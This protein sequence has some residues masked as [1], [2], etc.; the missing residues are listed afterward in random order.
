MPT[1]LELVKE[2]LTIEEACEMAGVRVGRGRGHKRTALCPLHDDSSPS[3]AIFL[4]SNRWMCFSG[5]GQGDAIDLLAKLWGLSTGQAL[6]RLATEL[7]I[8]VNTYQDDERR[9]KRLEALQQERERRRKDR[10][11]ERACSKA[12]HYLKVL[13]DALD[14]P[15]QACETAWEVERLATH[16]HLLAKIDRILDDLISRDRKQREHGLVEAW[17]VFQLVKGARKKQSNA[18]NTKTA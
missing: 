5:C 6:S 2:R 10:E 7:D 14:K 11:F 4:D 12:V 13:E 16:I 3:F 1:L 8:S 18:T 15:L 9:H 17:G